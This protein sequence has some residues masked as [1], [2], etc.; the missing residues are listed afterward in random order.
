VIILS[1]S[2]FQGTT[3]R[4]NV[5]VAPRG[6]VRGLSAQTLRRGQPV[7]QGTVE[8]PRV[9]ALAPAA[10]NVLVVQGSQVPRG[11]AAG[12]GEIRAQIVELPVQ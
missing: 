3:D 5:V 8:A 10:G 7:L 12:R 6:D 4:P 9:I 2:V 1:G 11:T